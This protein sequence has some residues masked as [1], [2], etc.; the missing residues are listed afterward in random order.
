MG[1]KRTGCFNSQEGGFQKEES[2]LIKDDGKEVLSYKNL[3]ENVKQNFTLLYS[4]ALLYSKRRQG[5]EGV[6]HSA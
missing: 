4:K 5:E 6:T 2:V 3:F 1:T